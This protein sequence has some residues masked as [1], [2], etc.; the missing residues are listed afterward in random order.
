MISGGSSDSLF[1]P[2]SAPVTPVP[3][4]TPTGESSPNVPLASADELDPI[5]DG[6]DE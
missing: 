5:E 2:K 6:G 3:A 1:L 4:A